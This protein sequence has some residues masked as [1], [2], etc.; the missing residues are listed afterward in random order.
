MTPGSVT[1]ILTA[2]LLRRAGA[3]AG[4]IAI[5]GTV[6][7]LFEYWSEQSKIVDDVEISILRTFCHSSRR[8][9]ALVVMIVAQSLWVAVTL[10]AVWMITEDPNIREIFAVNKNVAQTCHY[11]ILIL[12]IVVNWRSLRG[13]HEF[14]AIIIT[15][16][17]DVGL[18]VMVAYALFYFKGFGNNGW[19][20]SLAISGFAILW[21]KL[22][23]WAM[24]SPYA[25]FL[26]SRR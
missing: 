25:V 4:I 22:F 13:G 19:Q 17:G 5:I 7:A 14:P 6:I 15:S 26:A 2:T 16:L 18:L 23:D 20:L 10:V 8:V 3:S 24:S 21:Y 12:L 11:A 1:W 9:R